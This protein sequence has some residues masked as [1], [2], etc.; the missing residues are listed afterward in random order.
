MP[1]VRLRHF[2]VAVCGLLS[3]CNDTSNLA[4]G[5]PDTPAQFRST[6]EATTG[7]A[8][9]TL[10]K[11]TIPPNTAVEF[12]PPADIDANHVHT[13]VELIDIAQ[14]RNPT[15]RVAWEQA[16]QAAIKV[17]IAQAAYLPV[18]TAGALAGYERLAF[19]FPRNVVPA[20]FITSNNAEV[21]PQLSVE[22]LLLDF[23]RRAATVEEA[24]EL[25]I[26]ANADFTTA[27]QKLIYSVARAYFIL[28]G[29]NATVSAAQRG[30]ADARV[31]QESAQAMYGRGLGNEVEV[32]LAR[33]ATA[34]AQFDLSRTYTAQKEAV[35]SLLEAMDLPP[36]TKLRVASMSGRPLPPRTAHT[37]ADVLREALLRRPDLLSD[38]AKLRA[39]DANITAAHSELFPK[40][41]VG[42]NVSVPFWWMNVDNSPYYSVRQPQGAALLNLEWPL[43]DGGLL[44]NKLK[45]AE[46]QR[47]AAAEDLRGQTDQA[48]REVAL[49]YDQIE[50]GLQQ[51]NAAV[52]LQTASETAFQS[53]HDSYK[54]GVGTLTDAVSAQTG[55][56]SARAA[57]ARAHAQSLIN[58]AAL[59]FAAG[60]LT[61][62]TDFAA[63]APR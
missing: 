15:T 44:Q 2:A 33:R 38:V 40:V 48:L 62:S 4:P 55:L 27:H 1:P 16:R 24:S 3:A 37:V 10:A 11:F 54:A 29:A 5:T 58:G 17:G 30:L 56:A 7:P 19:P 61:S 49:A 6:E 25:S 8:P 13:L 21:V 57:V 50:T 23:G 14:R 52:A 60:L 35:S 41:T 12:P 42:A 59:A 28:D 32:D 51:Y 39:S 47:D 34:Q 22:Y 63:S 36:T 53:A 18:L 20:G 46:S 31:L 45:L 43:Y 9:A 26:A